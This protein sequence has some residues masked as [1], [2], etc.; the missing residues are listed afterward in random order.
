MSCDPSDVAALARC[1]SSCIP[2]QLAVRSYLL[3]Q[4]IPCIPKGGGPGTT[5]VVGCNSPATPNTFQLSGASPTTLTVSWVQPAGVQPTSYTIVVIPV[6]GTLANVGIFVVPAPAT[7]ATI[8][9]L[10]PATCYNMILQAN[11]GLC[12]ALPVTLFPAACTGGVCAAGT[13]YVNNTYLPNL[14]VQTGSTPSSAVQSALAQL[15][16]G[17]QSDGILNAVTYMNLTTPNDIGVIN[18][19]NI[20]DL[21]LYSYPFILTQGTYFTPGQSNQPEA[22]GDTNINGVIRHAADSNAKTNTGIT[23]S[24]QNATSNGWFVYVT[25][26]DATGG[27]DYGY[28]SGGNAIAGTAHYTDGK[29]YSYNGVAATNVISLASP[30][31]GFYSGQRVS[32][33][34]HRLYFGNFA[35][36]MAQIG[37][38]DATAWAGPFG[39]FTE[40]FW[41]LNTGAA[42]PFLPY[43]NRYSAFGVT[44]GMTLAQVTALFN[45]ID[46]FRRAMGGGFV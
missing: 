1:F 17:M 39:A 27:Y 24:L 8:T 20:N 18:D 36:P 26:I 2:D 7:F 42:A 38:T 29:A 34:D 19:A 4:F 44:T 41:G 13:N 28:S 35:N 16:C 6:G 33:T 32:G 11:K 25:S 14:A 31:A 12:P 46:T 37:A 45:R 21:V 43:G 15:Y 23:A 9:G 40:W 30:G 5:P 3:S 22:N 10:T